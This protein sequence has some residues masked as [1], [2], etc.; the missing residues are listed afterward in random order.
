MSCIRSKTGYADP[1]VAAVR[2]REPP[3]WAGQR[4]ARLTHPGIASAAGWTG[5]PKTLPADGL[6]TF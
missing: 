6:M 3:R 2:R 4:T 1:M 5:C